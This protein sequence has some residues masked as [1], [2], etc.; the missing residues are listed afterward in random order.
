LIYINAL[1]LEAEGGPQ[2]VKCAWWCSIDAVDLDQSAV[3]MSDDIH[4]VWDCTSVRA[5]H[6]LDRNIA[7]SH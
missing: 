7:P 3:G 5:R 1:G 6:G 4:P 2:R